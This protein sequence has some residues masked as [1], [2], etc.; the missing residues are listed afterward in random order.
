MADFESQNLMGVSNNN[1][2]AE[3]RKNFMEMSINPSNDPTIDVTLLTETIPNIAKDILK[4][5]FGINYSIENALPITFI[6]GWTHILNYINSQ[7]DR[8][9]A[10]DVAG[11]RVAYKTEY[12]EGDKSNNITPILTHIKSPVFVKQHNNPSSGVDFT[13]EL[14]QKYNAWRSVNLEETVDKIERDTHSDVLTHFG[15]DL[16]IPQAVLPIIAAFYAVGL[17]LAKENEGQVINMY[18]VYQIKYNQGHYFP[19]ELALIKQLLKGDG[20]NA[21]KND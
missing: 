16:I 14:M 1:P 2:Y 5:E 21:H 3:A 4:S 7:P 15:I 17:Q 6:T 9:F 18:N 12:H 8:E 13:Q 20:K 19:K 10:L 11:L